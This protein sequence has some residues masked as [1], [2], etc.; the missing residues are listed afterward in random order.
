MG[1]SVFASEF[2]GLPCLLLLYTCYICWIT[3]NFETLKNGSLL[4]NIC[5][6]NNC[7][8][9]RNIFQNGVA[10]LSKKKKMTPF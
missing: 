2:S 3:V 10:A 1:T 6:S 5:A 4:I 9:D 7:F 8:S